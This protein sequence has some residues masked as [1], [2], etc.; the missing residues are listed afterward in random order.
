[1]TEQLDISG[2]DKAELLVALFTHA[3]APM[4]I[5]AFTYSASDTLTVDEARNIFAGHTDANPYTGQPYFV[6]Y[7]KGRK[8]H[9]NLGADLVDPTQ[10]DKRNGAGK[11]QEVIS[12]L[13]GDDPLASLLA[14][15]QFLALQALVNDN[16][17][18]D[19]CGHCH[20]VHEPHKMYERVEHGFCLPVD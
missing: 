19:V 7:V 18:Q 20:S 8:L 9:I 17:E 10:Y 2:I 3:A 11:A 6:D 16:T 13:K 14:N 4:G 12:R 1:M 5:A 15:P